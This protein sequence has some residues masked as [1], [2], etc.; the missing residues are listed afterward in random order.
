V[1]R[2]S[3]YPCSIHGP[4]AKDGSVPIATA[5]GRARRES[6]AWQ[7]VDD[8][9]VGTP[10]NY[11]AAIDLLEDLG[12]LAGRRTFFCCR[13]F[14]SPRRV[15]WKFSACNHWP[16]GIWHTPNSMVAA[17]GVEAT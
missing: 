3:V 15:A 4:K 1:F 11:D 6:R 13:T 12:E 2:F 16:K 7:D 8:F 10:K 9:I 5:L 14:P 17:A